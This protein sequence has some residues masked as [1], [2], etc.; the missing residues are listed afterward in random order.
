MLDLRQLLSSTRINPRTKRLRQMSEEQLK[1]TNVNFLEKDE[2]RLK[3]D[4]TSAEK[5]EYDMINSASL[6]FGQQQKMPEFESF[7]EAL[8]KF[9]SINHGFLS[10]TIDGNMQLDLNKKTIKSNTL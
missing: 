4:L 9:T 1:S 6:P 3:R 2:D 8:V 7:R 5:A 10:S